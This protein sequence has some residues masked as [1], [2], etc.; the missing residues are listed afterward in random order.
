MM[1]L[2]TS[3]SRRMRVIVKSIRRC[4]LVL[5]T[6]PPPPPNHD[7]DEMYRDYVVE[8]FEPPP[9]PPPYSSYAR[10]SGGTSY[11]MKYQGGS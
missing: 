1:W 10:S 8:R 4:I 3:E 11:D 2:A 9:R 5:Y 6:Q 7:L